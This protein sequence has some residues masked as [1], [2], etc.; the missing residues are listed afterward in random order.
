MFFLLVGLVNVDDTWVII[1]HIGQI[2]RATE[3]DARDQV[4]TAEWTV[5]WRV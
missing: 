5:R 1:M 2:P 3:Q 4:E